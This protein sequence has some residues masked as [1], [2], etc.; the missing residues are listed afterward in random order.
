[1]YNLSGIEYRIFADGVVVLVFSIVL[2]VIGKFW[3]K[4]KRDKHCIIAGAVGLIYSIGVICFY[5]FILYNPTIACYHGEFI[6][7]NR[8]SSESIPLPFTSEYCFL[9]E[10]NPD[11]VFFLDSFSKKEIYDEEFIKGE[12]YRIYYETHRNIIVRVERSERKTGD[13]SLS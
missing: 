3:K 8:N 7:E 2:F 10:E 11:P 9:D 6:R 4:E 12:E 1:M 13:G 5:T